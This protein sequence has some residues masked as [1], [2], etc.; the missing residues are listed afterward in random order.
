MTGAAAQ[1]PAPVRQDVVLRRA[2]ELADLAQ[3]NHEVVLG[4]HTLE[5][6]AAELAIP[7]GAVAAALAE[8]K[9]GVDGER[10]LLDRLVG[11]RQVWARRPIDADE[12]ET[13]RRLAEWL[14]GGH[15]LRLRRTP[16]GRLLATK[17]KDLIAKVGRSVRKVQG[18]GELGAV[19]TITAVAVEA[20]DTHVDPISGVMTGDGAV[21]IVAD[22]GDRRNEAMIGGAAVSATTA[23]AVSIVA[24]ATTPIALVGLPVAAGLGLIT[25]RLWHHSNLR[26]TVEGIESTIDGVAMGERP[27]GMLDPV[28]RTVA[29]RLGRLRG[30][31][32][33]G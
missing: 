5:E 27:P 4:R 1:Q 9:A 31:G 32:D 14:E 10:G 16:D 2:L 22:V 17:R 11:P 8:A 6:I 3:P 26:E 13:A 23:A 28:S 15:G 18:I 7:P 21:V 33:E 20:S 24:I 19:R 30:D 25:S 29:R 12:E